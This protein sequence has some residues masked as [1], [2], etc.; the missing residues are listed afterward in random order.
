MG[1]QGVAGVR[2]VA[3]NLG[4]TSQDEP[5]VATRF[6]SSLFDAEFEDWGGGSLQ[7]RLGGGH[8]FDLFNLRI[9][10]AE[11]PHHGHRA[12]FGLLVDD[13]DDFHRRALAAGG[14]EHDPPQDAAGMPRHSRFEDPLGN[15]IVLWQR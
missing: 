8:D 15:R 1:M 14:K 5:G 13:V 6:W 10:G 9:R 2:L 11:D 4:V 7:V 3:V 12:A